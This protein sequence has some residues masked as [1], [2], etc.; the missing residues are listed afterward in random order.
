MLLHLLAVIPRAVARML[1]ICAA[2]MLWWFNSRTR[3]ITEHNL[4]I[5]FPD[6]PADRREQLARASLREL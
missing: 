2:W 4:E 6:M 5:S 3:R 1:A